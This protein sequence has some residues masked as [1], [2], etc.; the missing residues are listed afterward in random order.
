MLD[1]ID[2]I[3]QALVTGRT[4]E[5]LLFSL[6]VKIFAHL[7]RL[8]LDFYEREMAGRIMTRMT[9]DV[10]A[11]ATVF[12]TGLVTALVNI[13]TFVGVGI[14]LF[15][16]NAEL[17]AVTMLVLPP[18]IVD[19]ALVP[20]PARPAPTTRRRDRI[21]V[22]NAD[23]QESLSGRAGDAGVPPRGA[24]TRP[25]STDVSHG[26]REARASAPR[27]LVSLYFPFVEFL[28][29]VA[30]AIVLGVG[31]AMVG[32]GTTDRRRA[33]RLPALPRPVLLAGPAALAGVRLLPAGPDRA[34]PHRRAAAHADL[35]AGTGRTRCR[36]P[37][38]R[39][40]GARHLRLRA[41]PLRRRVPARRSTASNSQI[42]AGQTVAFVGETGAGKSTLVKLVARFYDPTAGAVRVDGVDLRDL[43]LAGYRHQLGIVPQEPFLFSGTIRD[44]IAYGRPDASDAE[45][46]AAA[47]AVGAH[48]LVASLPRRLPPPGQRARPVAVGRTAPADR[49]GPGRGW[50]T[51]RSCCST[52]RPRSSTWPPRRG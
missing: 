11:L 6:R 7:Q 50:S 31:A 19:H 45:V 49:P 23:L 17:A 12:Q 42:A 4:A 16:M 9:S 15:V 44:N 1:W 28:S 14:A 35:H 34:R 18:L 25:A 3:A 52:R 24:A 38:G 33:D 51:R 29:E 26:Y 40:R 32:N 20:Q 36:C 37:T 47:R 22:V 30:A 48:D 39:L 2:S 13:A 8:G 21:A 41:L 5:R 43:D 46:E 10:D 27:R